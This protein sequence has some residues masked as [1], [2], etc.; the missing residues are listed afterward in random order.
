MLGESHACRV[1]FVVHVDF[2]AIVNAPDFQCDGKFDAS[3]TNRV[4]SLEIREYSSELALAA[5]A[6]PRGLG[7]E[8][9][10]GRQRMPSPIIDIGNCRKRIEE[11]RIPKG[12]WGLV[13][14]HRVAAGNDLPAR[15][16]LAAVL[17][18]NPAVL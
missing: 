2:D 17:A 5:V 15:K 14:A 12:I 3:G 13:E 4:G 1:R 9:A 16:A 18:A 8:R 6:K 11:A 7:K 10:T